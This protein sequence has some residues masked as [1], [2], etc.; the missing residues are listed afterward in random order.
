[1]ILLPRASIATRRASVSSPS[2]VLV[3][4]PWQN[5]FTERLIGSIRR[6]CLDRYCFGRGTSAPES[7]IIRRLLQLRQNASVFAQGCADFSSDSS[8]QSNSF[9]PNPR[10]AQHHYVRV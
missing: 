6:E 1:M 5:G 2:G 7:K 4:A 3:V 10:R 9:T 8:D